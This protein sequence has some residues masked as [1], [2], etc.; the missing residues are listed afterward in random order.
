MTILLNAA[1]LAAAIFPRLRDLAQSREPDFQVIQGP[2]RKIYLRRWWLVPRNAECNVYLHNML[3]DDADDVHDHMYESWSLIL[4]DGLEERWIERPEG[5]HDPKFAH[6]G[7]FPAGS[8]KHRT[9]R[10]GD[11]VY[12]TERMAHQL[13]VRAPAWTLFATGPRVKSWGHWCPRTGWMDWKTY[14]PDQAKT[15]GISGSDSGQSAGCGG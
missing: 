10:A 12:R 13:L 15:R 4:T 2:E 9:L 11:V 3:A 7:G 8:Y 1:P 5:L 14:H 6:L